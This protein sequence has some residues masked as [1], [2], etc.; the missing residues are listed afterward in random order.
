LSVQAV[1]V[2]L[3][4]QQETATSL[5]LPAFQALYLPRLCPLVAEVVEHA[6]FLQVPEVQAVAVVI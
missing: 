4:T 5:V 1:A 2:V 6:T 3:F